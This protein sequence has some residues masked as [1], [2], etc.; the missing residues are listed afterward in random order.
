MKILRDLGVI[1]SLILL[2]SGCATKTTRM[3]V[4]QKDSGGILVIDL[5]SP[6]VITTVNVPLAST[7]ASGS[8]R[9]N[10]HPWGNVGY[11]WR[12]LGTSYKLNFDSGQVITSPGNS[13]FDGKSHFEPTPNGAFVVTAEA[14]N[15]LISVHSTLNSQLISSI[16][17]TDR[18]IEDIAICDDDK[19]ILVANY[20]K[21]PTISRRYFISRIAISSMGQLSN[22]VQELTYTG[23][24]NQVACAASSNA[25]AALDMTT[26]KVVSFTINETTGLMK[27]DLE[28]AVVNGPPNNPPNTLQP[29][30]QALIFNPDGNELFIRISN[31]GSSFSPQG[32]IE[33][34][35]FNKITGQMS[36]NANW[37]AT[38]PHTSS[39]QEGARMSMHPDGGFIYVPNT[40]AGEISIINT[41]NGS[42]A[43]AITGTAITA[44]TFISIGK[45]KCLDLNNSGC[46]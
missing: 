4:S 42:Q 44:P 6:S 45:V 40:S 16:T 5:D 1:I 24:I 17:L 3:M 18:T 46:P 9:V 31:G 13:S 11:A 37:L 19:T 30:P 32:W 34:F 36:Q 2:I 15:G 21:G 39:S 14:F 26:D 12:F 23:R 41:A 7:L 22:P 25:G 33:K 38:V 27:A 43:T 8:L 20:N 35:G 29:I 10:I 28:D